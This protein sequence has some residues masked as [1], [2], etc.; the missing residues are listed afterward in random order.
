ML[1]YEKFVGNYMII[2]VKKEMIVGNYVIRYKTISTSRFDST[3]FKKYNV[4]LY[5]AF[6]KQVASKRFSVSY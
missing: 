5:K 3:A 4:E 6:L 1:L 2:R